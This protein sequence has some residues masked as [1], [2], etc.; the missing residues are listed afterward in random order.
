MNYRHQRAMEVVMVARKQKIEAIEFKNCNV[1]PIQNFY[2]PSSN[3]DV[4]A[5]K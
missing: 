2:K 4:D 1:I 3:M 5:L